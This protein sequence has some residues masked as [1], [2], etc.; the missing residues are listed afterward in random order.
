MAASKMLT[1]M[2][3]SDNIPYAIR[4]VSNFDDVIFTIQN[5]VTA[6]IKTVFMINC[7]AVSRQLSSIA[8]TLILFRYF[9]VYPQIYDI[10]KH[11]NL[12]QG[13]DL[14]CYILDNHRPIHLK[15]IYSRHNVV[16]FDDA[17]A[18]D[19]EDDLPS[20]ASEMASD[21]GDDDMDLESS[22]EEVD[23]DDEEFDEEEGERGRP[24]ADD[25]EEFDV[26]DDGISPACYPFEGF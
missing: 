7:G 2:L 25:D 6:D 5:N 18:N 13:S 26:S 19:I 10:P 21:V 22:D 14:R 4:P 3:R 12:E 8:I 17:D 9:V 20:E 11:F 1:Q 23:E 24:V 16:V 15:N